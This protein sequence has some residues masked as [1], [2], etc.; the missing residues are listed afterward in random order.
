ML[1]LNGV[2]HTARPTWKLRETVRFYRDILGVPLVHAISARGW[3][4]DSHPDF[5]HFF[6]D[7]GQGSSIA[8]FYYI[9]SEEPSSLREHQGT[10][11]APDD[12]VFDATHVS[13]LVDSREELQ[14]LRQRLESHGIEASPDTRHETIE[15]IYFR[16]PNGYFL[17]VTIRVR[18]LTDADAIDAA[19]TIEA[20][21]QLE[22]E[23]DA[24]PEAF[25]SIDQVW[26]RK[27][28]L[29]HAAAGTRV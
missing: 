25:T 2:D 11:P 21:M 13:W 19:R 8:F 12:H 23:R 22:G 5:L 7:S 24:N 9:G 16:D 17:E 10:R 15:S 27:A 18:P 26:R 29:H 3:G 14:Q 28:A 4:T 20:A 1:R 6:F